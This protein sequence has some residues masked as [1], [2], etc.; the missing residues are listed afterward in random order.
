MWMQKSS[1]PIGM[2][3][4]SKFALTACFSMIHCSICTIGDHK[5]HTLCKAKI[6]MTF[7]IAKLPLAFC[8]KCL[9]RCFCYISCQKYFRNVVLLNCNIGL[10]V[11]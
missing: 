3:E 5:M 11:C 1:F 7:Q 2:N 6:V 4:I 10:I 8:I 9:K